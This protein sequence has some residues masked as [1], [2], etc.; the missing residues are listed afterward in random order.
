MDKPDFFRVPPGPG[1][2]TVKNNRTTDLLTQYTTVKTHFLR[3]KYKML[4]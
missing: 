3:D 1:L 2:Y 4:K